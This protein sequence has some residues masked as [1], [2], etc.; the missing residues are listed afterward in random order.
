MP[1]IESKTI[2][3]APIDKVYSIAMNV[4]EFATFMPDVESVEITEKDQQ[5]ENLIRTVTKWVGL[6]PEFKL[7]VRWTEEDI[8][9]SET[10]ICEFKQLSGDYQVYEGTWQFNA[11]DNNS[12]EFVSTLTYELEIP[13]IGPLLK[14][15][16][17]KKMQDNIDRVLSAIKGRA[18]LSQ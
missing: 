6:V 2:I 11:G 8:W 17:A 12:T 14:R 9:N 3:S 16:V 1:T 7:K 5:S 4:E 13:L 10:R 15:I 18:E